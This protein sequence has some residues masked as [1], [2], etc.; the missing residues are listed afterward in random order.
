MEKLKQLIKK[1]K[2]QP[3][4]DLLFLL[5]LLCLLVFGLVMLYSA[6]CAVG[7]YRRGD[8]YTYIRPQLLFA[9]VG[10]LAWGS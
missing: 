9:A 7:L 4:A 1:G 5:I 10:L 8:A 3:P 6:S 2:E